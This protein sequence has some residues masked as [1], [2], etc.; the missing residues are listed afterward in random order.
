LEGRGIAVDDHQRTN[1]PNIYAAGDVLG[2]LMLAHAAFAQGNV[3]AENALGR[4]SAFDGRTVPRCVYTSP[5]GAAV[6]LTE[7]QARAEGNSLLIG[8]AFFGAN[9]RAVTANE[10]EGLLKVIADSR[11]GAILGVHVV[12]PQA[13]EIIGAGVLAM[14]LEATLEDLQ[15]AIFPPPTLSEVLVEAAQRAR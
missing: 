1:L 15:R 10:A 13:S 2:R 8:R 3:V 9:G 12:G 6:G 4:D 7:A 14:Q 11:Y 5:E